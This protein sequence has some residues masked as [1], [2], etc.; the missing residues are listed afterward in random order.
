MAKKK[1][2]R[3]YDRRAL[4]LENAMR[5]KGWSQRDLAK[6]LYCGQNAVYSFL[7]VLRNGGQPKFTTLEKYA[8]A[9][10]IPVES[11]IVTR[12]LEKKD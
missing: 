1:Q 12:R 11:L 2:V 9:L 7:K 3:G 8:K 5:K 10:D 4:R 6:A